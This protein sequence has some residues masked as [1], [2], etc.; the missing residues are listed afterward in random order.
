MEA[1]PFGKKIGSTRSYRIGPTGAA[2]LF[3]L[4]LAAGHHPTSVPVDVLNLKA[5]P[6]RHAFADFFPIVA[7]SIQNQEP[8]SGA[9]FFPA[10]PGTVGGPLPPFHCQ[11]LVCS[12]SI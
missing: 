12:R 11:Y 5:E 2:L 6:N 9:F 3:N 4:Q 8:R 7:S 1:A 10:A